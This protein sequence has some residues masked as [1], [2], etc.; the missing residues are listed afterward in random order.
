M[1]LRHK[2]LPDDRRRILTI[3]LEQKRH[4][5][6]IEA[7]NGLS[8]IVASTAI[9][10]TE[11]HGGTAFDAIWVSSLTTSAAQGLPDCELNLIERRLATIEE[12]CDVT[13][14]P[15]IVD[16]DTGGEAVNFAYLCN[17]LE[18]RGVSA[19]VIEDKEYPKRNSLS[20]GVTHHLEDPD[21]FAEKIRRGKSV[22]LSAHFLIFARLE[23]LIAEQGVE[24]ALMRT[25]IYLEAGADGIMIHSKAHTVD[26]VFTYLKGYHLLCQELGYRKPLICVPTTYN[27]IRDEELFQ[28]GMN[29]VIHANH[30]LRASYCAMRRVCESILDYD[31]N[32]EAETLCVPITQLFDVV[33][34]N[35][36][37]QTAATESSARSGIVSRYS[38]EE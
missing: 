23:S 1:T 35:D 31:R 30:L 27:T 16:G 17:R 38:G 10:S 25:R 6:A 21:V 5:R 8:S 7:H 22:L 19:V 36:T 33:G 34:F 4:I 9:S 2:I 28:H 20:A 3:L 26:E 32:L 15:L 12:I 29:I 37:L 13:D 18:T 11:K 14:K 24:D